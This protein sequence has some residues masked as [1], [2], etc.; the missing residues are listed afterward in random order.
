M[1]KKVLNVII[2]LCAL[3]LVISILYAVE[4]S[5]QFNHG[6]LCLITSEGVRGC[7]NV[8][9][10]KYAHLLGFQNSYLGIIGFSL[11]FILLVFYRQIPL[12]ELRWII[13]IGMIVSS[14]L[15]LVFLYLQ[16]FVIKALC[17]YCLTVD[18]ITLAMTGTYFFFSLKDRKRIK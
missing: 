16:F 18:V 10:S 3:A 15:V 7:E 13:T 14:A 17:G 9:V 5:S 11:L 1:K 6:G 2:I 12:K 8:Y 4:A